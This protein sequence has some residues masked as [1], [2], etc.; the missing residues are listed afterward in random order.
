MSSYVTLYRK[1]NYFFARCSIAARGKRSAR[2]V[3]RVA[4]RGRARRQVPSPI[5]RAD[6]RGEVRPRAFRLLWRVRYSTRRR[7]AYDSDISFMQ[8]LPHRSR[9][10]GPCLGHLPHAQQPAH[11]YTRSRLRLYSNLR[12]APTYP[13]ATHTQ[14]ALPLMAPP[15]LMPPP[16]PMPL[17]AFLFGQSCQGTIVFNRGKQQGGSKGEEKD[18]CGASQGGDKDACG[19][20]K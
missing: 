20:S 4:F 5:R 2:T 17:F 10:F 3:C 15:S 16:L 13:P 6:R 7:F 18:A 9:L 19:A 11:T 8:A 12:P 1:G 14:Q